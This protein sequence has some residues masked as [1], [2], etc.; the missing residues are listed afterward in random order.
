MRRRTVPVR[1]VL[2]MLLLLLLH[3]L[4]LHHLLLLDVVHGSQHLLPD[5][6]FG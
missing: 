3:L 1:R 4:L 5:L 6:R 2:L